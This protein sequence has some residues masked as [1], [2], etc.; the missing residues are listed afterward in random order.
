MKIRSDSIRVNDLITPT[1]D[2]A[3]Y[4]SFLI[5]SKGETERQKSYEIAVREHFSGKTVWKSGEVET[6]KRFG[7]YMDESLLEPRK[8]YDV[9]V[10]VCGEDGE[11]GGCLSRK[12]EHD[13]NPN[14]S[15]PTANM[16][17]IYFIV[18]AFLEFYIDTKHIGAAVWISAPV[19][20]LNGTAVAPLVHLGVHSL[21]A[22]P[23]EQVACREV[24]LQLADAGTLKEAGL[25]VVGKRDVL[26]AQIAAVFHKVA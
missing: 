13:D 19:D 22:C 26:H 2:T 5:D 24:G 8:R 21:V 4:F 16:F 15:T 14:A 12:S 3:P 25:D 23:G 18:S 20:A 7:I 17:F 6:E 11:D 9:T 10:T 1:L